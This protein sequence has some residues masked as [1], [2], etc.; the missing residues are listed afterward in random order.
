M[1]L[2]LPYPHIDPAFLHLRAD[3]TALVRPD[4]YDFLHHWIFP[5]EAIRQISEIELSEDDIYDLLFYLILGVMVGGHLGYVVLY[6]LHNYVYNSPCRYLRSG[7]AA[8]RSMV[9][10]LESW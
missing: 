1:T 8:C 5:A 3:P 4:A 2:V 7:K 10:S 6:D 9:V